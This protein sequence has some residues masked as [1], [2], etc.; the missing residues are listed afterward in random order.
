M[1]KFLLVTDN[2]LSLKNG[3]S[4]T[5]NNVLSILNKNYKTEVLQ[6]SNFK[7]ISCP[8][9]PE[10]P[11]ALCYKQIDR[12]K[13]KSFDYIHIATEGPIGVE[14]RKIC[15]KEKI[16]YTTSF[17]T[18]FPEYLKNIINP[19]L[20]YEYLKWFH[21]RSNC[22]LVPTK[23]TKDKLEE[24]GFK[25]L[26]VWNRGINSN[27]FK[28]NKSIE[29]FENITLICVSRVSKEKNLEFFF[30]IELPFKHDKVL[31]G[32]GPLLKEYKLKY[33]N[34][35]FL[36]KME[37]NEISDVLNKS[38]IFFFPSKTDTFGIVI[39]EAIA[40]GLPVVAFNVEGPKDIINSEVGVLM[41]SEKDVVNA[42]EKALSLK[43]SKTFIKDFTWENCANF[44]IN[45]V[46][47][48]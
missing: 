17:H 11:V 2:E 27:I 41:E 25:N 13:I 37:H 15:K 28:I 20:T 47:K 1:K 7:T 29:K 40:C 6:P 35:K 10:I 26:K 19:N 3:V 36:G 42:C 14:V 44:L 33:R 46:K 16:N 24:I 18:N 45:C 22:V 34:V 5:W 38:H 39:L 30:N 23:S 9:Y 31:I 4:T 32:D 21:K 8:T 12:K 43:P 48:V